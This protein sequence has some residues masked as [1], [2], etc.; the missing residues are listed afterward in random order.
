MLKT[1]AKVLKVLSSDTDPNQISLAFCFSMIVGL[2][3]FFSLHNL[4]LLLAILVFRVNLSVFLLGLVFF[5][6]LSY[7]LSPLF[8]PVGLIALNA[9]PLQEFWTGL[10]NS[11]LF[12]MENF[13]NSV[14]MGSLLV[15]LALFIPLHIFTK[16]LIRQYRER[17]LG[18]VEKTHLMQVIKA[19]KFYNIYVSIA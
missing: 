14:V 12:R 8:H 2:T 7:A 4:L 5:S 16:L 9:Q 18:W 10:Y 6:G 11:A 17:L 3:P 19:S 13:N 15:S 1:I